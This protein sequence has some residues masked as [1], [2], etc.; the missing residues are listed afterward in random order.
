M[1][2]RRDIDGLRAVAVMGVILD[3]AGFEA[4]RAGHAGVDVFFVISGFLIGGIV[5]RERAEGRFSF[6]AFYARR[7]RR[8]LP[9]LFAM[10]LVTL[11]FAWAL[12]TPDQLRY[13]G[14]GAFSTLIF[15]PN[16]WFYNRIDYFNPAAAFDPLVHTWSLGVE[17]QFYIFL[18]LLLVLLWRF[19]RGAVIDVLAAIAGLSLCL[20]VLTSDARPLAAFYLI[21]TRAWELLAGVLAALLAPRLAKAVPEA[22]GATLA[23]L[24]LVLVAAGLA[25]IPADAAW[26]G[27]WALLPVAGT[28]LVVL[29]G[30]APSPARWVLSAAPF[31]GIGVVSYSAYLWH[32]PIL[33][34]LAILG[35]RPDGLWAKVGFVAAALALA[36]ASWRF[37]EQPFRTRRL[38]PRLGRGLLA[39]AAALIAAF[40]IGGAVT[41]GYPG[42]MSPEVLRVLAYETSWS[43]SYRSCIGGRKEGDRLDPEAACVHGPLPP[44]VAIWGD[45]HAAVLAEPLGEALAAH[46]IG[47]KELTVGSCVPIGGLKNSAL[48]RT[49]YC[50]EHNR[51]MLDHLVASETIDVVVL[52]AYWNS[53][54]ER[55]DFDTQT[56]DVRDDGVF[57]LPL[58]AS[59]S[60]SDPERLG[61]MARQLRADVA[62]LTAAGKHVVLL[63]PI[64]EAAFDPPDRLA[65]LI[66]L[67]GVA[68]AEIGFPTAAFEDYS[69]LSR[70]LLDAAGDGPLVHR[71]D[72]SGAFCDPGGDCRVVEA[73]APLFFNA[74]HLS[75]PGVAKVV[76]PLAATVEAI[77]AG[78]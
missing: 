48:K 19:G 68:P 24:G 18:P 77:L 74:N 33:G 13:Y 31:V 37:V 11:P 16:V 76:P 3:H 70:A 65:R 22:V 58:H 9:A 36:W 12:M 61:F 56:G 10:V 63:Y 51:K 39:G 57:A 66:W 2:Y 25:L 6:R 44:R 15:L 17:E 43:P 42:R 27:A 53:Y 35:E 29:F 1:D 72:V 60:I 14:G 75:L 38:P 54:T 52:N 69:R 4:I 47:L 32:Q 34:F 78:S 20:S 21:H 50:A 67:K 40:A 64:P 45:S 49:E 8:I 30:A 41:E 28:V 5:A 23:T 62:E 46:G 71:L 7:A 59:P 55:R 73:G 26:P